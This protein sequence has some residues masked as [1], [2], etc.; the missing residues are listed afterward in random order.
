MSG[1][2][3]TVECPECQEKFDPSRA[4]GWCTNPDCGEFRWQSDQADKETE[5]SVEESDISDDKADEVEFSVQDDV[6]EAKPEAVKQEGNTKSTEDKINEQNEFNQGVNEVRCEECE[7]LVPA[8]KFCKS[9]G[10]SLSQKK[11]TEEE[12][13]S[14]TLNECPECAGDVEPDWA[15]CPRCGEGLEQYRGSE[16]QNDEEAA[17]ADSEPINV[18]SKPDDSASAPSATTSETSDS[19][20]TP[21]RVI[22]SVGNKEIIAQE[23]DSLGAAVRTAYVDSGGD[24]DRA[25][26]IS[27]EHIAFEREGDQFYVIEKSTN[28]TKLNGEDLDDGERRP[29]TDGDTIDF[30]DVTTGTINVE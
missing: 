30:A 18:E 6:S 12:D 28:G 16:E 9:C 8:H 2:T 26:W 3:S 29:I 22:V 27:R 1:S 24:S 7:D 25:Q 5:Q 4:G 14:Q 21:E 13:T 11:E 20:D 15:V 10:S 23:Q 19:S 17:T